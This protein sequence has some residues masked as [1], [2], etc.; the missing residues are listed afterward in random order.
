MML[1]DGDTMLTL[2]PLQLSIVIGVLAVLIAL[3]LIGRFHIVPEDETFM[4]RDW[5]NDFKYP[6][7]KGPNLLLDPRERVIKGAK[8]PR[9]EF[10]SRD[11]ADNPITGHLCDNRTGKLNLKPQ[12]CAPSLIA[13]TNEPRRMRVDAWV[14]FRA[15][16]P[17]VGDVHALGHN[18]GRAMVKRIESAFR[19][20]FAGRKDEKV[21]EDEREIQEAVLKRL[22][23]LEKTKPLGVVF[24]NI[25]FD[26]K[27]ERMS[28]R[29]G[30]PSALGAASEDGVRPIAAPGQGVAFMHFED[31]DAIMNLFPTEERTQAL[32][33]ILEMQTRRDIAA[34]LANSG[35]L[36]VVTAQELG[37]TSAAVQLDAMKAEM[38][39]PGPKAPGPSA[40]AQPR[41]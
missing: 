38:R 14:Q 21:R 12:F 19:T 25:D 13:N 28:F 39:P 35:Q 10:P 4:I 41:A 27:E 30:A 29:G 26:F 9:F 37:L 15:D 3:Y 11:G 32:L 5:D 1:N 18:F 6:L 36:V 16:R 8:Q 22:L 23:D 17:R 7:K 31:F 34:A 33:F 20:E 24:E 2:T 40:L